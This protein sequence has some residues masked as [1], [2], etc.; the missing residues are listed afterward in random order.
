MDQVC[1]Q[2]SGGS[3]NGEEQ[4]ELAVPSEKEMVSVYLR[5]KP[6]TKRELA[7][8]EKSREEGCVLED[9]I[10]METENQVA[11]IAPKESQTYKNSINGVGTL[12]HRYTFTKIFPSDTEQ[13]NIFSVIVK[14][15]VKDFLEGRNQLIFTYGATSSGKTYT[16]Q[17]TQ[18]K[19]GILPRALD[20]IFNTIG[21]K[22]SPDLAVKPTEFN[23]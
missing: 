10:R 20:I 23:L 11:L 1:S 14:P 6:R 21:E 18:R 22:L 7:M 16:F 3:F 17:G 8:I 5:V 12:T 9:V 13:S 15:R 2:T 4:T 19:C